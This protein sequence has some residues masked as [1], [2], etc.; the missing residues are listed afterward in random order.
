[1]VASG[2]AS[3]LMINEIQRIL[4]K[5]IGSSPSFL[6]G[7]NGSCFEIKEY[8]NTNFEHC[9]ACSEEVAQKYV[10]DRKSFL[11]QVSHSMFCIL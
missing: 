1:M 11:F 6:R 7:I 10:E 4:G 3:E 8:E 5:Q 9:L 2:M